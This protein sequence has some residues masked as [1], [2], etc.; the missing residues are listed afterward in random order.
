MSIEERF[1]QYESHVVSDVDS[2]ATLLIRLWGHLS[3][4]RRSQFFLVLGLT[5]LASCFEVLTIGAVLPFLM[6]LTSPQSVFAHPMAK[7]LIQF[8]SISGRAEVLL[9][10]TITFA[11][12]AITAGFF[13]VA[14]L[15]ANN[16]LSC[17]TGA[18][19]GIKIYRHTLYQPYAVHVSRNTSEVISGVTAK[20]NAVV[21]SVLTPILTLTSAAFMATAIF[22]TLL[23]VDHVVAL[24][25]LT[26][27]CL[28]YGVIISATR[29]TLRNNGEQATSDLNRAMKA[30]QEGLGGIRDV[31]IDGTQKTYCD[32]YHSADLRMRNAQANTNFIGQCPRY[33]I[34]A[35][36]TALIGVIAY[37]LAGREGGVGGAL[38]LLGALALGAQRMLPV[39][40]Q[41]YASWTSIQGSQGYLRDTLNLLDQPLPYYAELPPPVPLAFE[42]KVSV[43]QLSFRYTPDSAW[44]LRDV[45]LV[46]SKGSRV[47]FIGATGSG[48]S[49]LLDILMGLIA[50]ST[51]RLEVDGVSV[52]PSN[53]RAWQALVA[54]VPQAIFLADCSVAEN[55]AFGLPKS[56]IDMT[57]V[58][59]AAQQAQIADVIEGWPKQYETVVGERGVKLSGGQRQRIGIARALYKQAKVIVFDEAT[60]ALDT[61]TEAAVMR[62]IEGLGRDLTLFIVAHRLS[63]L[64]VCDTI[65]EIGNQG[66]I[67][68]GGYAEMIGHKS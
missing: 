66:V 43:R 30:L 44:V 25:A 11:A 13:R 46:F 53:N 21:S 9:L 7:S 67:R 16:H 68:A 28:I 35:M 50:P 29:R 36:G 32:I 40:Q 56:Q 37:T 47:G 60:S 48:K 38:P 31:L 2:L 63:T 12:A 14:L 19:L 1:V 23:F 45:D 34:E 33:L 10:L 62:A 27:F 59:S 64:S 65:I 54:H 3:V 15:W 5:V 17:R 24:S 52:T 39:I 58:K 49:T 41:A 6:A 22:G 26:G 20:A 8:L 55:I 51:G 42:H 57:R 4:R 61:Q 18:D